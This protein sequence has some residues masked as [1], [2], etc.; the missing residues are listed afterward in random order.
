MTSGNSI[1]GKGGI[2]EGRGL[3][4]RVRMRVRVGIGIR[5]RVRIWI[6]GFWG[7]GGLVE[8]L[9]GLGGSTG[10]SAHNSSGSSSRMSMRAGGGRR[11]GFRVGV[12]SSS[13]VVC[14][15]GIKVIITT[16]TNIS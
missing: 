15:R 3:G 7:G 1:W 12:S 9:G 5:I 11:D 2:S 13:I 16:Y 8:L 6:R 4:W 14:S 10:K